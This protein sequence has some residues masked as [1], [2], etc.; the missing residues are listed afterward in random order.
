MN[1][2]RRFV[3]LATTLSIA[4]AAW[5][6]AG[7]TLVPSGRLGSES[8][9]VP[10][11]RAVS[12]SLPADVVLRQA[13]P[14]PVAIEADDNLLAEIDAVVEDGTLKLRFKRPLDIAGRAHLRIV[15]TAPALEAIAIAGSG[16]VLAEKLRAGTLAASITGSGDMRLANLE[17]EALKASLSGSGVL[18]VGGHAAQLTARIAGSGD[19][20]A[21]SL[22]TRRSGVA[23]TGS[24]DAKVWATEAL[25][26][27]VAGSGDVRYRGEPALTTSIAGSGSVKRLAPAS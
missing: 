23:I 18:R 8:R 24:G 16:N 11:F 4:T 25:S 27:R 10:A 21:A 6:A 17:A 14:A 3:V 7:T 5:C 22:E 13:P 20:D 19:I 26:A 12:L 2:R 15:V 9:P 1:V